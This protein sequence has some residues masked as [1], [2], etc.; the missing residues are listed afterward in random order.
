MQ[1]FAHTAEIST[2]VAGG[3]L[4]F[5]CSPGIPQYIVTYRGETVRNLL[6]DS[7]EFVDTRDVVVYNRRHS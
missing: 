2:E 5:L 7:T 3:G 1:K 4:L 6:P